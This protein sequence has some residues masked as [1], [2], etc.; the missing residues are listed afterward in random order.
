ME[1]NW[2]QVRGSTRVVSPRLGTRPGMP[3]AD[4]LFI[5]AFGPIIIAV[6]NKLGALGYLQKARDA[7]PSQRIF[8]SREHDHAEEDVWDPAF[9]DDLVNGVELLDA[10]L[11]KEAAIA[12]VT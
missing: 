4:L 9:M 8:R 1:C 3:L 7:D 11:W 2:F 5:I 6:N 12:L 10:R